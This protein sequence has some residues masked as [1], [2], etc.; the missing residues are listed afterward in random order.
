MIKGPWLTHFPNR[1]FFIV[2]GKVINYYTLNSLNQMG[3]DD[4]IRQRC[5]WLAEWPWFDRIVIFAILVNSLM[6]GFI[7]YVYQNT[8]IDQPDLEITTPLTNKVMD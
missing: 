1:N 8:K 6:L 3:F 7:D 2:H 4:P 5:I